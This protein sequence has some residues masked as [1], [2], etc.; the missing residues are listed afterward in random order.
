[1]IKALKRLTA[2]L[3]VIAFACLSGCTGQTEKREIDYTFT[4]NNAASFIDG[5]FEITH[6]YGT[7][8][9]YKY[10]ISLANL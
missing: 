7:A 3:F 1:M 9:S 6:Q 2:L 4:K 10:N 5:I 8:P